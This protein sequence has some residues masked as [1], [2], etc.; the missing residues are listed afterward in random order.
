MYQV[1]SL[2]TPNKQLKYYG[3]SVNLYSRISTHKARFNG[4]TQGWDTPVY[5]SLRKEVD[6]FDECEIKVIKEFDNKKDALL[7]ET[8]MIRKD[9]NLNSQKSLNPCT[10]PTGKNRFRLFEETQSY[11]NQFKRSI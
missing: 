3:V 1:Y 11:K 10:S 2:T 5:C 8:K 6:S 4:T 7:F 9:G